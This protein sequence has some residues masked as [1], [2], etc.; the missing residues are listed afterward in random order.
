M[1]ECEFGRNSTPKTSSKSE[2][3]PPLI[4]SILALSL[5]NVRLGFSRTYMLLDGIV[6][7]TKV[8]VYTSLRVFISPLIY[9]MFTP[10]SNLNGVSIREK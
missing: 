4:Y 2:G 1:L 9:G 8:S 7:V 5:A 10:G 3:C 6:I